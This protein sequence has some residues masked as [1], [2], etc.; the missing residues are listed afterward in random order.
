MSRR[1][2][3]WLSDVWRTDL[4]TV[5]NCLGL[6]PEKKGDYYL[7]LCP[8]C[9]E[10]RA[11][12]YEPKSDSDAP[13]M[14]CNRANN[15]GFESRIYDMVCENEGT[16]EKAHSYLKSLSGSSKPRTY[17]PRPEPKLIRPP[18]NELQDLWSAGAQMPED[19]HP[20]MKDAKELLKAKG[21]SL[22]AALD[23]G[24]VILPFGP[25]PSWWPYGEQWITVKAFDHKGDW[26]SVHGRSV[27]ADVK[28]KSA[29]PKGYKSS[30]LVFGSSYEQAFLRGEVDDAPKIA[31][32]E[33]L[34]D[35]VRTRTTYDADPEKRG[36][37][38]LG[39]ASGSHT[40][41]KD[42][43]WPMQRMDVVIGTDMDARGNEYAKKIADRLPMHLTPIRRKKYKK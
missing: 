28:I 27:F 3:N 22:E 34:T 41:I 2:H 25:F 42:I 5:L 40:A 35:W 1:S 36:I 14:Q 11:F 38:V 32:V 7:C 23:M 30:G 39:I 18:K 13:T 4:D 21:S 12:V 29:W 15:C 16:K 37:V 6:E 43:R 20:F 17:A 26:V 8:S 31:I 10:K 19:D 9:N 24:R 33:G